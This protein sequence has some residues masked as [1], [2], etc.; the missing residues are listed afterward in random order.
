[1]RRV[2]GRIGGQDLCDIE[3]TFESG[4]HE[5]RR[6]DVDDIA[7]VFGR[8]L[9]EAVIPIDALAFGQLDAHRPLLV[10]QI[11][12]VADHHYRTIVFALH[13]QNHLSDALHF[14]E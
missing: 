8:A 1:M 3:A 9:D 5:H 12:F 2:F 6:E 13:L 4:L 14:L 11:A 10:G 7:V